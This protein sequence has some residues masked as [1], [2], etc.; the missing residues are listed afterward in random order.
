LIHVKGH[1]DN[2]HHIEDLDWLTQINM[3]E[4]DTLATK[5]LQGGTSRPIILFNPATVAMLTIYGHVITRRFEAILSNDMKTQL[6]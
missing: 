2:H 6:C 1:Q 5:A 3:E 4:A